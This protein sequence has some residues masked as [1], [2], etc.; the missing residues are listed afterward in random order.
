MGILA[1]LISVAFTVVLVPWI[2]YRVPYFRSPDVRA[3][4]AAKTRLPGWVTLIEG[5][6]L[7]VSETALIY[8]FFQI[9]SFAYRFLHP[10]SVSMA[11]RWPQTNSLS[12]SFFFE[13]IELFAP[14]AAA[15]PLGM[16]L[17][18]FVS[19]S[20]PP[21]RRAEGAIMAENAPGYSWIDLNI[22][23]V[24]TAAIMV[25]VSLILSFISL[26]RV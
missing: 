26:M 8:V 15:L 4:R 18:N 9:E 11:S 1:S 13:L 14:A 21:I 6:I 17:A 24:K 3:R 5:L 2:V 20:I 19:W 23:L 10:G 12:L 7:L 16:I 25:P 22:G